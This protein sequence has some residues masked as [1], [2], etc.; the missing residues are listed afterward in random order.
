MFFSI[1]ST[2]LGNFPNHIQLG[3]LYLNTDNGWTTV[4]V[5]NGVAVYKGYVNDVAIGSAVDDIIQNPEPYLDGNFCLIYFDYSTKLISIKHNLY[6]SFPLYYG[7]SVTNLVAQDNTVWGNGVITVDQDL[8]V[9]YT[10]FDP[11]GSIDLSLLSESDVVDRIYKRLSNRVQQFLSHNT[12]PL[13]VFLSGGVDSMLVFSFIKQFTNNYQLQTAE[14]CDFDEFWCNNRNYIEE[15]YWSYTQIHHW[16]QPCVLSSGAPGDEFLLR[17][18][19]TANLF[20][21]GQG[22]NIPALLSKPSL[23]QKYFL[24]EKHLKLFNQQLLDE[25]NQQLIRYQKTLYAHLCNANLNDWQHWHLGNTLTYTP[26]RDLEIFKLLLRLPYD[27]AV[28][29][30]LDSRISIEL[31]K[32]NDPD[33]VQYLSTDKNTNS[34]SNMWNYLQSSITAT[35]GQ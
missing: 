6:R 7:Q 26:L 16:R 27:S 9:T 10:K 17:S 30:I 28:G 13:K 2:P 21:M 15:N 22:T 12:L 3:K 34:L 18:P 29:Q 31:I 1:N 20:L 23:H 19:T 33:L 11:V 24:K 14:H 35:S 4:D 32:R 8:S 25:K 5:N